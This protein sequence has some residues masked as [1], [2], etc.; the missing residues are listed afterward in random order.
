V[1]IFRAPDVGC[2]RLVAPCCAS[3][4]HDFCPAK[5]PMALFVDGINKR[6]HK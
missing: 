6:W 4:G 1:A 5:E 3:S 2:E